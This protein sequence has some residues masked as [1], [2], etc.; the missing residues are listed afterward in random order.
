[1]K[2][3][4]TLDFFKQ[5]IMLMILILEGL[6]VLRVILK[7]ATANPNALFVKWVYDLTE[8]LA[9]PFLGMFPTAI[10]GMSYH[11]E[12]STIFGILIYAVIGYLVL[13]LIGLLEK[14]AKSKYL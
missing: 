3:V 8:P 12:F 9:Q 2:R 11:I 1:M 4:F 10:P 6:L 14:P 7:L 5:L 13:H